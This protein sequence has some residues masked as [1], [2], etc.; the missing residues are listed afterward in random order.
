MKVTDCMGCINFQHIKIGRRTAAQDYYC[1][2]KGERIY[3]ISECSLQIK[4]AE[5]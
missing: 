4:E 2:K 5:G 1:T 3:R